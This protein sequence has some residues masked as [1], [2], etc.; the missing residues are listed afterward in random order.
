MM[1]I[2]MGVINVSSDACIGNV[3][4]KPFMNSIWFKA[5]AVSAQSKNAGTSFLAIRVPRG[6]KKN[7]I[8]NSTKLTP[9]RIMFNPNGPAIWCEVKYLIAL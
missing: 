4:D 5:I 3:S 1:V 7:K 6:P 2:M 8:Q 9:M